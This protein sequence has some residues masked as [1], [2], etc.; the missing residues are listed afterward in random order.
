MQR[1]ERHRDRCEDAS[2]DCP[3][4]PRLLGQMAHGGGCALA[5]QGSPHGPRGETEAWTGS[6]AE[7][8]SSVICVKVGGD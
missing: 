2:A 3:G 6:R 8:I 7:V 1:G 5:V 4:E